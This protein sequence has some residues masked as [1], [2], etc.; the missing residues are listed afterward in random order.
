VVGQPVTCIA[1]DQI[2]DTPRRHEPGT[3]EIHYPFVFYSLGG[4]ATPVGSA[5]SASRRRRTRP[6]SA[7]CAKRR[8]RAPVDGAA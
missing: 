1:H 6:E 7:R 8:R 4:L 2:A 3:G 5:A